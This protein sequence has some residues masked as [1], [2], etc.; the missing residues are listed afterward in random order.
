MV[1]DTELDKQEVKGGTFCCNT[2]V[3]F[4]EQVN[5]LFSFFS[6]HLLLL[7]LSGGGLGHFERLNQR[8]VCENGVGISLRQVLQQVRLELRQSGDE[9]V[10][11]ADK[12]FFGLFQVRLLNS[13][14]HSQQLVFQTAFSDDEID[15]CALSCCFGL[16]MRVDQFCL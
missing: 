12:L 8:N 4:S 15:D 16:V 2:S 11:F 13:N 9:L 1:N 7:N 5:R 14:D 6:D 3:D 10:L